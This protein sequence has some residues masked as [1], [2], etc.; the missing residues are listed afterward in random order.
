MAGIF[1]SF[2]ASALERQSTEAASRAASA[3][4]QART[5]V[6]QVEGEIERLLMITEALWT[7]LKE[8]HG[9][10]DEDLVARIQQI[11]MRDGKYDGKVAPPQESPNCPHCGRKLLTRRPVCL[12]CGGAMSRDPFER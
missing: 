11:D 5:H 9:Y 4:S 8:K 7:M 2:R 3:A 12:Y 10:T 6:E 1:Y